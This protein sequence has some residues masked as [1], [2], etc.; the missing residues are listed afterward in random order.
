MTRVE[1]LRKLIEDGES[2]TQAEV[3]R[4]SDLI[5]LDIV[6][7]GSEQTEQFLQRQRDE[8]DKLEQSIGATG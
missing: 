4:L 7:D 1:Q 6:I 3:D 2:V 5:M 8:D